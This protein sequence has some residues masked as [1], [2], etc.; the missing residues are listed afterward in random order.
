MRKIKIRLLPLM[1]LTKIAMS[2]V[3]FLGLFWGIV[4]LPTD[5][6]AEETPFTPEKYIQVKSASA[7]KTI[8]NCMIRV[9]YPKLIL[10][11]N[12]QV[13]EWVVRKA[14]KYLKSQFLDIKR[15]DNEFECNRNAK[16]GDPSF[17]LEINY[18]TKMNEG[19]LLSIYYFAIGYVSGAPHPNQVFKGITINLKDGEVLNYRNIFKPNS[20]YASVLN[21]EIF[22]GLKELEVISSNEEFDDIRKDEYE[23]YFTK[24]SINIINLYDIYVMQSLEVKIPLKNIRKVLNNEKIVF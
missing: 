4:L 17:H 20:N 14:N 2:L 16:K 1:Y 9:K 22:N 11:N 3:C 23:F 24:D 10:T 7:G 15:F 18:E 13:K 8:R 5:S 6:F 19:Y 12:S 21:K